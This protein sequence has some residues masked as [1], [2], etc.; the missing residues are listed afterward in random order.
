MK[1]DAFTIHVKTTNNIKFITRKKLRLE[2]LHSDQSESDEDISCSKQRSHY[3][4]SDNDLESYDISSRCGK[5]PVY[6]R[7]YKKK[8]ISHK[9]TPSLPS[10]RI[11][12]EHKSIVYLLTCNEDSLLIDIRHTIER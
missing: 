3:V 10:I 12:K 4:S 5:E 6:E 8:R 2:E 9:V 1:C 11:P 7:P